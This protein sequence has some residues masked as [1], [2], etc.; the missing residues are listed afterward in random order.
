MK[1][2]DSLNSVGSITGMQVKEEKK[3]ASTAGSNFQNSLKSAEDTNYELY[4]GEMARKITEQGEKLG[5]KIDIRE[6]RIYKKLISEFIDGALGSSL[7]FSRQSLLDRRG[8]H[9]VYALI[10]KI[11]NE[12]GLLTEDVISKEKDNIVILQRIDDI[13][14]LVLDMIL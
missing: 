5:K 11:N 9:K 10:K 14:G 6:L 8:R 1:I 3:A 12:I 7:K 2:R 4:I 13:R